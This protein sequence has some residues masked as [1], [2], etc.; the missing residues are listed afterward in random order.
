[1]EHCKRATFKIGG[2]FTTLFELLIALFCVILLNSR[3][4]AAPMM[5]ENRL[6]VKPKLRVA[7]AAVRS[8]FLNSGAQEQ[9]RIEQI[10]VR[11]VNVPPGKLAIIMDALNRNPNIEFVEPDY[12]IEPD[13]IPA[14]PFYSFAWHLPQ[15]SAPSAW[16]VTTGSTNVII[17]ILDTGVDSSHPELTAKLVPGWNFY[18][19]N[20]DT[21][22]LFGHGTPVAGAAAAASNNGQGVSSVAW[23]CLLMPIR[24]SDTNGYGILSAM[25]NGLTYAADRGARVA[26]ISF[27]A[28]GSFTVS[29]AAAYFQSKGGVVTI[30]AGNEAVFDATPDNPF[31]LTVSATDTGDVLASFSNTGNNIDVCAPGV[32]ILTTAVGGNYG[33]GTGTS[34]SA[35]VV[36]GVAAL[37]ISAN[38]SLS[39]AQVQDI[40]KGS[41]DDVGTPG[42]DT[43]FGWGRVNAH[44]AVVSAIETPANTN[45]PPDTTAPSATIT[46]PLAGSTLSGVVTI[47][48]NATDNV[49]VTRVE[50]YMNGTLASTS[51]NASATLSWDTTA[52]PDGS[53]TLQ[54]CAY[55]L[56]GN[57]GSSAPI[58]VSVQNVVTTPDITP[59]TVQI[60]SP[61]NGTTVARSLKIY[62]AADDDVGVIRVDL[63]TDGKPFATS[64]SS[65]P[66][67]AWNTG[68]LRPGPHTLQA[69]AYD[70]AGNYR[71]SS[72]VTIYR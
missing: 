51:S 31:V 45:A 13:A 8:L 20:A 70:A 44:R 37:V 46:A 48:I 34:F 9:G 62:V 58:T 24:I 56:A 59:P 2:R 27:R 71:R 5:V 1:M 67:F 30:S 26:N 40:L 68:K 10:N 3:S 21:S 63:L 32:N 18:N 28:S 17:A 52:Y 6:L 11:I 66:V 69:V 22:D 39:G 43:S 53:Y 33:S 29:N 38:P 64:S 55:D 47:N 19:D 54:A 57:M 7:E 36:A 49:G 61:T 4:A 35:P 60:T 41:V 50:C 16:D 65:L 23:N 12:L 15:I 25:A 14:D 42:W 72:V